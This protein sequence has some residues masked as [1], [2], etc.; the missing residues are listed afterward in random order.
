MPQHTDIDTALLSIRSS[1]NNPDERFSC[2]LANDFGVG[3]GVA[4]TVCAHRMISLSVVRSVSHTNPVS[5]EEVKDDAP[6]AQGHRGQTVRKL[7]DYV[8]SQ[9]RQIRLE[10]N[11]DRLAVINVLDSSTDTLVRKIPSEKLL[12]VSYLRPRFGSRFPG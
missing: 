1:Q 6:A 4:A 12:T 11:D 10:T 9:Q 7:Q 2:Y 8:Q 5:T 3:A